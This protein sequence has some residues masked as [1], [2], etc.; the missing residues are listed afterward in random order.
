MGIVGMLLLG[1][2]GLI[3]FVGSIMI[4]I[5]AFKTSILWGLGSIFIPFVGLVFVAMHWQ[6]ASRGFMIWA[7]GFVLIVIGSVLG[8]LGM[9]RET[10]EGAAFLLG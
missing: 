8:G 5:E 9:P 3:A 1:L 10:L 2:G 6:R 4:L 7:A